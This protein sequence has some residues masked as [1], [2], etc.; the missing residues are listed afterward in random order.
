MV[1][2]PVPVAVA[3]VGGLNM[4]GLVGQ[5]ALGG[6]QGHR[7]FV[8]DGVVGAGFAVLGYIEQGIDAAGG[9]HHA[10]G[11]TP[12]PGERIQ[13]VIGQGS[14]GL[15]VRG[16]FPVQ[17]I[18]HPA[19]KLFGERGAGEHGDQMGTAQ[20]EDPNLFFT[21]AVVYPIGHRIDDQCHV[22]GK[23]VC[24][25][26]VQVADGLFAGIAKGLGD[27]GSGQ[28]GLAVMGDNGELGIMEAD[29]VHCGVSK[30]RWVTP[31]MTPII[32]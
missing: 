3:V 13:F 27:L 29:A 23:F 1:D 4:E 22:G 6:G 14:E 24:I 12:Q 5:D 31:P 8:D 16:G 19:A 21:H 30:R 18:E 10:I 32:W 11:G 26:V 2:Q 25:A 17:H 20:G 9:P 28:P 15:R 7:V